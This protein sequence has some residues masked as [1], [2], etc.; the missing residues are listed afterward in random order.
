MRMIK[1]SNQY[2]LYSCC[3]STNLNI[4]FSK[5]IKNKEI[6]LRNDILVGFCCS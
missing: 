4:R 2:A 5:E 6:T 3:F 1:N